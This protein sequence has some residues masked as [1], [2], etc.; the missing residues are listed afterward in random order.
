MFKFVCSHFDSHNLMDFDNL[1]VIDFV[2]DHN[3]HYDVDHDD[4]AVD[5]FVQYVI[6]MEINICFHCKINSCDHYLRCKVLLL[7]IKQL[8]FEHK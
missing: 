2:L 1:I 6:Y 8:F 7:E 3:F 4:L 5:N